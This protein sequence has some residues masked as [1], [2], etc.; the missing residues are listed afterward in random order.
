MK[1]VCAASAV[2]AVLAGCE[3]SEVTQPPVEV[4]IKSTV[5]TGRVLGFTEPVF[6]THLRKDGRQS[7]VIGAR[8]SFDSA[9]VSGSF[10][11]PAIVRMPIFKGQPTTLRVACTAPELAG[12]REV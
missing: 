11:T 9:E 10:V 7:E 5:P 4:S 2:V 6:R 8:C 3:A 12:N 1:K